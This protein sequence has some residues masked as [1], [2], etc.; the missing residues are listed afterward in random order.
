MTS[1]NCLET[2]LFETFS[3]QSVRKGQIHSKCKACGNASIIDPK[4]KLS[5]FILRNPPKSTEDKEKKENGNGSDEQPEGEALSDKDNLVWFVVLLPGGHLLI[6][7]CVAEWK[8][9]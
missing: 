2:R 7:V 1:E 4:H 3:L 8:W 9:I 5:T 6:F